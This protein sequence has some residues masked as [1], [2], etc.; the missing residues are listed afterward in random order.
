LPARVRHRGTA[1][2]SL[3]Q[4][5]ARH[6]WADLL[7]RAIAAEPAA[8][9]RDGGVIAAGF[10]AELDELRAI[11]AHCGEF[12]VALEARERTRTG[13]ANLK[14]EYNRVHG[15]YIEVTH[16]QVQKIPDDYRRRQTLKS[17]ERYITP[18]LKSFED[19]ALSAQDRALAR[20]RLLFERLIADLAPA[21]PA[22]QAVGAALAALAC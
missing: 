14:V 17:A 5:F 15:F 2:A 16:A 18:E 22:L 21:I 4:P 10:D 6:T 8:Q 12:L 7:T 13:F 11:D 1:L 3:A 9:V 20:E 19:R